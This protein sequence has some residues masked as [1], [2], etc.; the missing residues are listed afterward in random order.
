M[1][2]KARQSEMYGDR[3][4]V[5]YVNLI[6]DI[7][8]NRAKGQVPRMNITEGEIKGARS[9]TVTV[10]RGTNKASILAREVFSYPGRYSLRVPIVAPERSTLVASLTTEHG[11]YFEDF[12]VISINTKFY[13]WLKYLVVIPVMLIS[14]PLFLIDVKVQR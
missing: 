4:S 2:R 7:W 14:V 10:S 1:C 8:D 5:K 3:D 6:V 12:I 9:Y 13:V 11:Q